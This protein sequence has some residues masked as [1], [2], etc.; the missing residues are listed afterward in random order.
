[1]FRR[2][3]SKIPLLTPVLK[4]ETMMTWAASQVDDESKNQQTKNGYKFY[5]CKTELCFSINTNG[6]NVQAQDKN[7]DDRNPYCRIYRNSPVVSRG[8]VCDDC[9]SSTHFCALR[10]QSV[11]TRE[12]RVLNMDVLV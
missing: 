4:A 12:F 11:S 10:G 8:P 5:G 1:M 6:K 9:S 3:K 2:M 7:E